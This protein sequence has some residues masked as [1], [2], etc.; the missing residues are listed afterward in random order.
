LVPGWCHPNQTLVEIE[1]DIIF[2]SIFRW[3]CWSWCHG[4][5][6]P[7]GTT[8]GRQRPGQP[9]PKNFTTVIYRW[10]EQPQHASICAVYRLAK[11]MSIVNYA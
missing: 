11:Q 3:C 8:S 9:D 10:N 5:G 4:S 2:K 6:L 7:A 1:N